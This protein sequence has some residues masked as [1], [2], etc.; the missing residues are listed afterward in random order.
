MTYDIKVLMFSHDAFVFH[1]K[2]IVAKQDRYDQTYILFL[3]PTNLYSIQN[4]N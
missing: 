3:G 4:K 1:K 2:R